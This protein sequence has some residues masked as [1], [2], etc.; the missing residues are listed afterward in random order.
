[1]NGHTYQDKKQ[2]GELFEGLQVVVSVLL[3]WRR[4]E[5][6]R[7]HTKV[8]ISNKRHN[9]H[10]SN[11]W[12]ER[13]SADSHYKCYNWCLDEV[14]FHGEIAFLRFCITESK[15]FAHLRWVNERWV[16]ALPRQQKY[17]ALTSPYQQGRLFVVK[18][19]DLKLIFH[20][21]MLEEENI[22][23]EKKKIWYE[24]YWWDNFSSINTWWT[25]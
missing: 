17:R 10:N 2:G 14:C 6:G 8:R 21:I 22:S 11:I 16:G 13:R 9:P 20:Y 1:M 15:V 19:A 12:S 7:G 25:Y 18:R 5:W 24:I 23:L 3:F 4:R